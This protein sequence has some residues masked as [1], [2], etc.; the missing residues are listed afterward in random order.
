[1]K[2]L[3]R[4]FALAIGALAVIGSTATAQTATVHGDLLKDWTDMKG[5]MTAIANAM[6]DDKFGFKPTPAQRSYGEHVM[7][8]AQINMML[9]QTVGAKTP[10]P[11]INMKATTKADMISAMEASFDYGAAVIKEFDNKTIQDTVNAAFL[12]PSTHPGRSAVAD[13]P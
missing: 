3:G 13:R 7:H 8:I 10:A 6:P 5:L 4:T 9:M 12:G 11:Q 1:M 2:H